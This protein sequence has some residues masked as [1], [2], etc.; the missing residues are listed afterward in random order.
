MSPASNFFVSLNG[1]IIAADEARVSPFDHGLL[2]GDG[3]FETLVARGGVPFAARR[4]WERLRFSCETLGIETPAAKIVFEGMRE[5]IDANQMPDARL[6]VTVTSGEGPLGSDKGHARPTVL[7]ACGPLTPWPD[8]ESLVTV[9][10]PRNERGALV[11]VK[12][13]SYAENVRA[14]AFA[15]GKG[16]GEALFLNTRDE[17]CEG[18]GSNVFLIKNDEVITPPLSSGCLAGVTR[19]LV[20][21]VCKGNGIRV[22]ERPIMRSEAPLSDELFITSTT[23]E[24]HPVAALD[25]ASFAHAPGAGTAKISALFKEM[26]RG[27]SD[28]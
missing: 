3:A 5:V 4:H 11:G 10:W 7:I 15:R 28:P 27:H 8:T 21:E 6:R 12:A 20:I 17:L 18:A 25:G 24:V 26:A 14:L 16:A 23:R 9:P 13:I 2:V 19:A 22:T 1:K